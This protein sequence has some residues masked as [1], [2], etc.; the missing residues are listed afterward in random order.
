MAD[1]PL[2]VERKTSV[3]HALLVTVPKIAFLLTNGGRGDRHF[4][5]APL[6][7]DTHTGGV[8]L[9]RFRAM[10]WL[11]QVLGSGVAGNSYT[12]HVGQSVHPPDCWKAVAP[13]LSDSRTG[14]LKRAR[15]RE[16]G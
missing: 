15:Q 12:P 8:W 6:G 4:S 7:F 11:K 10:E 9:G 3:L 5:T 14:K 16:A 13:W 1:V 2:R